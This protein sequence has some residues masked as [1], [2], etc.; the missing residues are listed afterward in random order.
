[1]LR[2]L[3]LVF[4]PEAEWQKTALKPP[5]LALALL[6]SILPLMIITLGIEGYSLVKYGAAYGDLGAR[7]VSPDRAIKYEVFYGVASLLVIF[8]GARLMQNMGQSFNLVASYNVCFILMAFG[9]TPI[10]LLR[11]L[12]AAPRINTW[13]CWAVGVA[14]SFRILYHGVALWLRPE[15]T[16]G[17]GLFLVS[18]IYIVVLS[19]LVH[20]ASIQVLQGRFLKDVFEKP[21]AY[22]V[23]NS[24]M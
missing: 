9:Y 7:T 16:K 17:F 22:L 19:A 6:I 12:D 11:L 15:Q 18:S 8:L 1:M 20:F 24:A 21:R 13:I 23:F 10:F 2:A 3:N 5:N 4:S 14:L